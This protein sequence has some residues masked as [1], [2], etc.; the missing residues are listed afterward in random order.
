[1][2]VRILSCTLRVVCGAGLL[3]LSFASK[4]D[5]EQSAVRIMPLGDS[6][7][8]GASESYREPLWY[9]LRDAGKEVDFVGSMKNFY[10]QADHS[11]DPDHEGHW[12]WRADEVLAEIDEWTA[13]ADPHIVLLH[14]G[15]N[16][17]GSG[18][19]PVHTTD[20][21]RQIIERLRHHN[22]TVHVLLAAIIPVDHA[23]ANERFAAFNTR[24]MQLA[25]EMDSTASRVILVD[26]FEGFDARQDTYDGLH[27]NASG[28]E[29]MTA[30]W[31]LGLSELL[32]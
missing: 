13:A 7:T 22:S 14:L 5:A 12:G 32:P 3:C 6:I 4:S 9:A 31:M 11:E 28:I 1:M 19:D 20:E 18:Q 10:A 8:Q 26:Q 25:Q 23:V 17:I 15:T 29:K 2:R 30:K 21:I 16:D 24:L 27:P